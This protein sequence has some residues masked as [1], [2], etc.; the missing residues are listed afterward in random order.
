MQDS[1]KQISTEIK[2]YLFWNE[3]EE[4]GNTQEFSQFRN[5]R[6]RDF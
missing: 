6:R 5:N 4:S 1:A 2:Y 3:E